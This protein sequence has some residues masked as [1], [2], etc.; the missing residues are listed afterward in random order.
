MIQ[1]LLYFR[2]FLLSS[3][4][5]FLYNLSAWPVN[6]NPSAPFHAVSPTSLYKRSSVSIYLMGSAALSGASCPSGKGP[7]CVC[8]L[9]L[10]TMSLDCHGLFCRLPL[11]LRM[12]LSPVLKWCWRS[13]KLLVVFSSGFRLFL[14]N[15][16]KKQNQRS[17]P[18]LRL[19]SALTRQQN[20]DK[21]QMSQ[22]GVL[23]SREF[24][25]EVGDTCRNCRLPCP[26]SRCGGRLLPPEFNPHWCLPGCPLP[27]G[28]DISL[29]ENHRRVSQWWHICPHR[30]GQPASVACGNLAGFSILAP[31]CIAVADERVRLLR[32]RTKILWKSSLQS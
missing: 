21:A 31:W 19:S 17:R 2:F 22:E 27:R 24:C 16:N 14:W 11:S 26:H 23:I 30:T 7:R 8:G 4:I 15:N 18:G 13:Q 25:D 28:A 32:G 20:S 6:L 10:C 3:N 12:E 1:F 29:W 5:N 9:S